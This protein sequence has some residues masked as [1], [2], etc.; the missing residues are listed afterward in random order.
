M[1]WTGLALVSLVVLGGF[2]S[3]YGDLQGRRW[4]KK[5]V[6][7]F[8]LRPKH[9]A[10]LITSLTGA[11]VAL[12]SIVTVLAVA[13]AIRNVVLRGEQA[14]QENKMLNSQLITQRME[15]ERTLHDLNA[16]LQLT[17]NDFNALKEQLSQTQV[18]LNKEKT[19]QVRLKKANERL[20]KNYL[21][22]QQ[23]EQALQK[24]KQGLESVLKREQ[25]QIAALQVKQKNLQQQNRD[26]LAQN[27]NA[28]LLNTDLGR[29]NFA[30]T[31][32]KGELEKQVAAAEDSLAAL[33]ETNTNLKREGEELQEK[34]ATLIRQ[35]AALYETNRR[36]EE[37]NGEL[38][39]RNEGLLASIAEL[40]SQQDI[41]LAGLRGASQTVGAIRQGKVI[42]RAGG[43]LA[44]RIIPANS[45]PEAVEKELRKLLDE[46]H[47]MALSLK[48][49]VGGNNRA[50]RIISKRV[51][52]GNGVTEVDENASLGFLMNELAGQ[53]EPLA[54]IANAFN[55][56]LLGEQA[57]VELTPIAVK[58]AFEKGE[59]VASNI[60]NTREP[61]EKIVDAIVRF[62]NQD[63]SAAAK[64]A[65][66]IAWIDPETGAEQVGIAVAR[67]LVVLT[68]RV[69]KAG[70]KVRLTAVS[71]QTMSVA[72]PLLLDFKVKRVDSNA[73]EILITAPGARSAN[74]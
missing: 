52:S 66:V 19:E 10:I 40:R 68:D 50:V 51:V 48:A 45:R 71:A 23:A 26:M 5:R 28:G 54:I 61:L 31:R 32:R 21:S 15:N 2:I 60:I 30:L 8:G 53:D 47:G 38:R 62:L 57:I 65:G 56:T 7:W 67:D 37:Y 69:R 64:K 11:F 3:Y 9:T 74:R 42:I 44:R 25:G 29:E 35:N 49:G 59:T 41:Y 24:E 18:N 22:L 58:A 39:Q 43:E 14:I 73:P 70:G 20:N 46:A 16:R 36:S 4:G 72:D 63:V 1:F 55:N 17:Q 12:L 6:S 33:Q 34:N 27:K 13:P